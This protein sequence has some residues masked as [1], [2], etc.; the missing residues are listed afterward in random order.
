MIVNNAKN[1]KLSQSAKNGLNVIE[2]ERIKLCGIER[3]MCY[4]QLGRHSVI[5]A[6][7]QVEHSCCFML[8]FIV[9]MWFHVVPDRY[10]SQNLD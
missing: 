8:S 2:P 3:D 9:Y 10:L 5:S 6:I 7:I 4:G 1:D